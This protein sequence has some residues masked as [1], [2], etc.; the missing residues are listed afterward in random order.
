MMKTVKFPSGKEIIEYDF[1]GEHFLGTLTSSL[2]GYTPAE[3]G[4]ELVKLF[5]EV[6]HA[7]DTEVLVFPHGLDMAA[8]V[9]TAHVIP[10][11]LALFA[12]TCVKGSGSA[13]AADQLHAGDIQMEPSVAPQSLT[14][15]NDLYRISGPSA[16]RINIPHSRSGKNGCQSQNRPHKKLFMKLLHSIQ[17]PF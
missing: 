11:P 10:C 4:I 2:H 5:H 16:G 12:A 3:Q 15:D 14:A 8:G 6:I 9:H 13:V 7:P 1:E 17:S